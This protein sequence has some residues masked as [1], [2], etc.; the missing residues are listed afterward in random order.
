MSVPE[1]RPTSILRRL[2]EAGVD[3]LVIGGFAAIAH[4]SVLLTYDLDVVPAPDEENLAVLGT[5]LVAL[6]ARLRGVPDDVPFV[7]DGRT[8][9][10]IEVLTL[11]TTDGPLDVLRAPSGAPGYA[12]MRARALRVPIAGVEVLVTSLEDLLAMKRAAGRP[13]DLIAIEELEAIARLRL[14][15]E[16]EAR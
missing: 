7:A 5:V 6:E 11:S 4:G 14:R 1:F 15:M 12:T 13:K 10:R 16:R 9:R 2:A 8:L 3:F